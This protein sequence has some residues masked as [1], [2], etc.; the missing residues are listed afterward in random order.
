MSIKKP[1]IGFGIFA[2]VSILVTVVV[3][4]TLARV[5]A[6]DTKTYSATFT[7][8][9]GLREGDDVRMAGVR[10]G[11]VEKIELARDDRTKKSVANVTFIVQSDQT[12][13]DDTKALVRYQN[14]IGQRYVAL[15]PGEA[16]NPAPL[17]DKASI[18]LERTE[19][20]F[21]VS[22]LLNGFQPLFQVLQPEQVNRLSET[23]IQALQGDG[24]SLSSFI[25]QAA[26]LATDF[27]RRDAILSDVI[28]N[29]SGV[30]AGLAKRGDELET[31]VTQTRALIGG[32]YEQGQ[33]LLAS[34]E[35]IAS[36]TTS[37]V[38]M[39]GNIQPRLQ[40][41]QNSTSAAL[42]LLLDNGAKLDQ[43]AIDLPHV[44]SAAGR[45]TSEGA[46]ANAY[47]CGLDV[48]LYGVLFPRG[49]FS[50]IGGTAHSAVC[51]P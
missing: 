44:L 4:N 49:L 20:S 28:A 11:K 48:S 22:G 33:S 34:T 24:V 18:P 30:M 13:Y 38:G 29:L 15:A 39:V 37:L 42:T 10:V 50:Q 36:A 23:F 7:D 6:G 5:V 46:Y 31:L 47:L 35:Q 41:A 3:W 14:L 17:K 9:L 40:T 21:D 32:L 51:R 25:V 26:Q 43:A 45:H 12:I 19:P 8:V 2:I 1:L 16:S 27:Q